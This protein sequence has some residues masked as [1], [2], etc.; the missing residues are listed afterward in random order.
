MITN[1]LDKTS[2]KTCKGL[3]QNSLA[4]HKGGAE[5]KTKV[6]KSLYECYVL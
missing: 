1:Y 5:K 2:G 6:K 3:R 4:Q